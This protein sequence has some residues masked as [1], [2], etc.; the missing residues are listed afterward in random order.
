[1]VIKIALLE[2]LLGSGEIEQK[3]KQRARIHRQGQYFGDCG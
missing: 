2:G 1:M 3:R